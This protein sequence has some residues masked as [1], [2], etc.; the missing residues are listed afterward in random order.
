MSKTHIPRFKILKNPRTIIIIGVIISAAALT[1]PCSH[2]ADA[3]DIRTIS[4][5]VTST[6]WVRSTIVVRY[7]ISRTYYDIRLIVPKGVK[8]S[9]QGDVISFANINIG[10]PV[11]VEFYYDP[12][13]AAVA[14][15]ISVHLL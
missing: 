8:I 10:D 4:G 3:P 7:A 15:N 14:L 6:D 2:G 5:M 13:G 9:K 1:M 12:Q 11:T